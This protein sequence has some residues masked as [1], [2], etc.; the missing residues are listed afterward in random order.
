[1]ALDIGT[2][3]TVGKAKLSSKLDQMKANYAGSRGR[4]IEEYSKTG[5]G[6]KTKAAYSR[7][8]TGELGLQ[9]YNAK[10]TADAVEKWG[11]KFQA[12]VSQ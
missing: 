6:A 9:K 10:M 2:M 8:M 7:G 11:R 3:V 12:G 4:A 5:F 1:M